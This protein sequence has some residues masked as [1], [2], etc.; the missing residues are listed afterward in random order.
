LKREVAADVTIGREFSRSMSVK[1]GRNNASKAV[2]IIM[3]ISRAVLDRSLFPR[4]LSQ[5]LM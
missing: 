3:R 4:L 1:I 5:M 2:D